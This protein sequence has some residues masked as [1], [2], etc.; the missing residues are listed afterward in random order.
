MRKSVLLVATTL[1]IVTSVML[2]NGAHARGPGA[3]AQTTIPADP[4]GLSVTELTSN[5]ISIAWTDN[6]SDE[7]G[8]K[9]ERCTGANCTDFQLLA[10]MPTNV[11]SITD[12]G[13]SKNRTY[14]YRVCAY[15]SAGNSAYTN[16]TTATTL[17]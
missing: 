17:R 13:L 16:T 9:I 4:T 3:A 6:S 8:F 5:S 15:N 14:K 2:Q 1:L 10:T 11:A 7:D 12:W